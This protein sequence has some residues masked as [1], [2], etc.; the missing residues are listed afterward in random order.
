MPKLS[1][2]QRSYAE[3]RARNKYQQKSSMPLTANVPKEKGILFKEYCNSQGK[4]VNAVLCEF[5]NDCIEK[6]FS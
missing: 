6:N 2:M 3:R 5:V 4:T 1:N